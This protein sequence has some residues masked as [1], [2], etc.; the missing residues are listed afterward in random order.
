[1]HCTHRRTAC[2][3][4]SWWKDSLKDPLSS[5]MSIFWSP[6][7]LQKSNLRCRNWDLTICSSTTNKSMSP[8]R[9]ASSTR[10]PNKYSS[11]VFYCRFRLSFRVMIWSL[12]KRKISTKRVTKNLI[13][14]DYITCCLALLNTG[15]GAV[16]FHTAASRNKLVR[17][18][19]NSM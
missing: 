12:V 7:D 3:L 5:M 14:R 18:S 11:A 9:L 8:P 19:P 1:M 6:K 2:C 16:Y 13:K 15:Y 4:A 17:K 10:L